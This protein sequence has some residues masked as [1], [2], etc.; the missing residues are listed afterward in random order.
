MAGMPYDP[1]VY[2][3][4]APYYVAGRPPYSDELVA[5]LRREVG[6][7]PG[8]RLLDVGCGPGVL[9]IELAP[10][11]REAVGLDPDAGML[12]EAARRADERGLT[13]VTWAGAVAE[14]LPR[15][16]LG[17]FTLATFGQSFQWTDRE[18]VAEA[19]YDL[20]V[21]GGAVVLLAHTVAGRPAPDGPDLPR[22]PHDEVGRLVERYLGPRRRAGRGFS[23]SPPDR[24][25]DALART[26]FGTARIAFAPGRADVVRDVDSVVANYFSMSWAAPHL[27]GA[28][29]PR[30]EDDL[31]ALLHRLSPAGLFWDWPGD[32]EM[33]IATRPA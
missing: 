10:H 30:F 11:V 4:A 26:R 29:R 28:D 6:L 1:T 22:M 21:P 3:G 25:E 14:D 16:G 31:R 2:L 20:L 15:L 23:S 33:V 5:T 24:Y 27:F 32:T 18:R 17:T 8:T 13:N 7:G 19:V 9:T 12:A